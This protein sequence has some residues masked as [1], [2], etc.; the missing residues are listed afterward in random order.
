[1][2]EAI[3][4]S[5]L[6][7]QIEYGNNPIAVLGIGSNASDL[8]IRDAY[9]AIALKIYP[10]KAPSDS[11]REVH[12]LLFQKVQVAYDSLLATQDGESGQYRPPKQLPET[13]TSLH[14]RNVAFQEALRN[15]RQEALQAKSATDFLKAAKE[16]N[17]KA[18]NERL[19]EKRELRARVL[20]EEQA[21]RQSE[22]AKE[23]R[24]NATRSSSLVG[25]MKRAEETKASGKRLSDWEEMEDD[26]E[27][28]AEV[29]PNEEQKLQGLANKPQVKRPLQ[30]Q[31]TARTARPTWDTAL[32]ERLVSDTEIKGRWNTSLLSGG[33]SGSVSLSQKKQKEKNA[34]ARMHKATMALCE[35][36]DHML[37]PALMGNRTFSALEEEELMESAF[38][39][40]ENKAQ[41]RTDR[42]LQVTDGD[43]TEQFLLEKGELGRSL[44]LAALAIE[45]E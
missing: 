10:D 41:A 2:T 1:M 16:A 17:K 5:T 18:K 38:V 35:E 24:G 14:A 34:V 12:T 25:D 33:R 15:A 37:K 45:E 20:K 36:A 9:R 19:A 27:A 11:V 32:D 4:L 23:H 29:Q 30:N 28:K 6:Y 40:T 26:L 21:K 3:P 7:L 22:I 44:S 8:E 31:A 39:R 42:F 43:V 13:L